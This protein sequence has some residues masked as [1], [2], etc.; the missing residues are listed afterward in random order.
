MRRNKHDEA[1]T[2]FVDDAAHQFL[3]NEDEQDTQR[4]HADMRER[5]AKLEAQMLAQYSAM[6]AYATIAQNITDSARAEGRND[7]D[8]SQATVIGLV[9]RVRREC[10]DSIEG[11]MR[12][13]GDGADS[14]GAR[15]ISLEQKFDEL[16]DALSQSIEA[17]QLLAEQV[18][19][20]L[21]DKMHRDGWLVA[22]GNAADLSLH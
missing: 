16:A 13:T 18:T 11:V 5:V 2:S 8:R 9:E 17:Q 19:L 6:A 4:S 22:N 10:A 1:T 14:D 3:P 21:E 7:L 15:L 20:L 12:R